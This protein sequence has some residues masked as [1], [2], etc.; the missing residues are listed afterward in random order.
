MQMIGS[1]VAAWSRAARRRLGRRGM[2]RRLESLVR[3]GFPAELESATR[4][5]IE[6]RV[7]E[8]EIAELVGRIEGVRERI[9]AGG[10]ASVQILYSPRP[11]SAGD[12]SGPAFRPPPGEVMD[13]TMRRVAQTG[14]N[15]L[16]GTF[17]HLVARDSD[18]STILELGAC[19]GISGSYLASAPGCRRFITIE[20]SPALAGLAEESLGEIVSNATVHNGLFDDILDE[21]LPEIGT[22]DF[23]FIDGH[24]EKVATIHYFE[25]IAPR[26]SRGAVVVFDDI[27]WS[28][29]M[30]EMWETVAARRGFTDAADFGTVGVCL[31]DEDSTEPPRYWNLQEVLGRTPVGDPRGWRAG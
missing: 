30:R 10:D 11:G 3:E 8:P 22:I 4:Y 24:H 27:S 18:A 20:G 13:F 21:I 17:L 2:R 28:R 15:R 23:A 19:A 31:W 12:Q 9:A 16:W 7:P 25:R 1:R 26:L 6:R 14:K 5:L 29:D